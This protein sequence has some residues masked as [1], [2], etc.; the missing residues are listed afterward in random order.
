MYKRQVLQADNGSVQVSRELT[1]AELSRLS[2]TLNDGSLSEDVY[3]RQDRDKTIVI[4]ID[5]SS[6]SADVILPAGASP[7]VDNEGEIRVYPVDGSV[8]TATWSPNVGPRGVSDTR[9]MTTSY[10]YDGLGRLDVYKRQSSSVEDIGD[11]P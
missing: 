2:V 3:K 7:E 6:K 5:P 8:I 10:E 9:G 1:S 4:V 11:R